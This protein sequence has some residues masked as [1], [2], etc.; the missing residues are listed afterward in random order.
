MQGKVRIGR[1]SRLHGYKGEVSLKFDSGFEHILNELDHIFLPINK[2]PVPLFI[3]SLRYTPQGYALVFFEGIDSQNEAEKIRGCE[4][5]IDEKSIS[6]KNAVDQGP[7]E[8]IGYSVE[9]DSLGS[10][11]EVDEI[12]EHPGNTFLVVN[13]HNGQILIPMHQEIIRTVDHKQRII[14]IVAPEGLIELNL[15]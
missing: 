10:V 2:K 15:N 14:H 5:W 3:E 7:Q 1:V 8:L 9:D 12:V 4:I 6:K 11:G 13:R